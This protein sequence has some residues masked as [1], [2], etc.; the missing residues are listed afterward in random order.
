[1]S[2]WSGS[3]GGRAGRTVRSAALGRCIWIQAYHRE[4]VHGHLGEVA[5]VLGL[6]CNQTGGRDHVGGHAISNVEKDVLGLANL[7]HVLDIPVCSLRCTVVA[8]DGFILA[9]LE[10]S[11][12][13]VGLGY[14]IDERRRLG[15]LGK[16]V[17]VP[18]EN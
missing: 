18:D 12:A 6:V 16:Q 1:M 11:N 7:R 8:K 4:L 13:A 14:D 15:I 5:S 2:R 10:E 3:A 17:L 9:R